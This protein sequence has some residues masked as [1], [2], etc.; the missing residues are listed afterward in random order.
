MASVYQLVGTAGK[1]ELLQQCDVV[2]NV[3]TIGIIDPGSYSAFVKEESAELPAS[4]MNLIV[5]TQSCDIQ[6]NKCDIALVAI[7]EF[8][9]RQSLSKNAVSSVL[10]GR[11]PGYGILHR[12]SD[13]GLDPEDLPPDVVDD[14]LFLNF[15]YSFGI[16]LPYLHECAVSSGRW[17][18]LLS[19]YREQVSQLFGTF[20]ISRVAVP[21]AVRGL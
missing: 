12:L 8:L 17:L 2:F 19:P 13:G 15:R 5:L 4:T 1:Q 14:H 18:R 7:V 20:F 16:P 6:Q 3:P 10:A 11:Q 21:D 9:Q